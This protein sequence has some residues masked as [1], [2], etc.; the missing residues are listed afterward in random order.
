MLF[1]LNLIVTII[2]ALCKFVQV[3]DKHRFGAVMLIVIFVILAGGITA[4]SHYPGLAD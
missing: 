2:N 1:S 3:L 4:L